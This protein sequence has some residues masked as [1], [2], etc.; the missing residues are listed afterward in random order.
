M[1]NLSKGIL[2]VEEPDDIK[3]N[4]K[5]SLLVK[6]KVL[7]IVKDSGLEPYDRMSCKGFWR[8]LL[9]RESK[10][11]KQVLVS[12]VVDK[13]YEIDEEKLNLIK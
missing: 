7:K 6:D 12:V 8:V 5:E 10:Q 2:F 9:F 1:G 4:S 11:T 13:N 3:V